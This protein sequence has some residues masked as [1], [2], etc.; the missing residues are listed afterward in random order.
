MK[1][2][3]RKICYE[4]G[5]VFREL[6][7]LKGTNELSRD[8]LMRPLEALLKQLDKASLFRVASRGGKKGSRSAHQP[9][10]WTIGVFEYS[11]QAKNHSV[12]SARS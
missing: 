4:S 2:Q 3:I 6:V 8:V 12:S 9:E 10:M 7:P 1:A 5:A 11:R